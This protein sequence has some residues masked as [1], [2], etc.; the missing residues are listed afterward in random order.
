MFKSLG[1]FNK[2]TAKEIHDNFLSLYGVDLDLI[3]LYFDN[4]AESENIQK[5]LSVKVSNY[6]SNEKEK[7]SCKW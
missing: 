3:Y 4:E 7:D 1:P 6:E 5:K 2:N